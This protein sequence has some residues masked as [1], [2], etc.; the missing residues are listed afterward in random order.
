VLNLAAALKVIAISAVPFLELRVGIPVG[1]LSGFSPG[2]A[3][4]LGVIGN[5]LQVPLVIF[6]MYILRNF[7][8][9]V[10]FAARWLARADAA[11]RR[12]H[13][14]VHRYGWI[15]LVLFIVVPLPGTGLFSGAALANLM[16]MP[17][18]PTA[19]A[20]AGGLAVSGVL[21]GAVAT[22]ALTVFD[23]L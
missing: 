6:V 9:Q 18:L 2:V 1:I 4:T 17:A 7:A 14:W 20:M 22:G 19:L 8:Q 13:H 3:V 11:A 16:R 23:W 10:P 12:H 15:G 5:A 21:V